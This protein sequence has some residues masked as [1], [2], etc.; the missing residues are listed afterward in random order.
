MKKIPSLFKRDYESTRL[1]YNEVVEG[2]EWVIN[3][4]G[5]PTIKIDGTS[6]MINDGKLYKRYDVKLFKHGKKRG[7][8]MDVPKNAIPCEPEPDKNTGHWP[9]W[10]EV[11]KNNPEDKWHIEA[12]KKLEY[13][14]NG[15][16]ELVGP[17]VQGN[18]YRYE[19][20]ILL[21]H[22]LRFTDG[23]NVPRNYDGLKRFFEINLIEGIVWHHS[24]G[25]MV[26]IRRKDFGFHWPFNE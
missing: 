3:G 4:E 20:H 18:P 15:T 2:S 12:F 21:K 9:H 13:I 11:N 25:R 6:C 5:I 19:S 8:Q 24:D 7:K 14:E 10:V 17:K 23:I 22:G 16:Y 1:V 26:K